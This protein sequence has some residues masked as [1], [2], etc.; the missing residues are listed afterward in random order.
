MALALTRRDTIVVFLMLSILA[1]GARWS[2]AQN[3]DAAVIAA[4]ERSPASPLAALDAAPL[5][6]TMAPQALFQPA[7][8]KPSRPAALVP[9]YVSFAALQA[10][11]LQS[12]MHGLS[13]GAQ[14]ANPLMSG[15]VNSPIAMTAL[16]AGMLAGVIFTTEG[17]RKQHPKAA[18]LLMVAMNS[19]YA[20][21]VAHNVDVARQ[22]R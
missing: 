18:L 22:P 6:T 1:F 4:A 7:P 16:K 5:D 3:L 14:E 9:L 15:A 12:T 20:T 19:A 13:H 2:S 8:V 10:L 21:I 11:D 17:L